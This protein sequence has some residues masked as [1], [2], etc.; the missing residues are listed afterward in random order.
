MLT[1]EQRHNYIEK[2]RNLPTEV[3]TLIKDLSEA[4]LT[5]HSLDNEWAV[6][7]IVHHLADSHMN[8]FIRLKMLLTEDHPT[9][10][11]YDQAA[12]AE[13]A[14]Q[15]GL[16]LEPSLAILSGLHQRWVTLFESLF[17]EDWQRT[18]YHPEIGEVSAEDILRSYAAHGEDHL[19]QMKRV[20]AAQNT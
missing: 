18:A 14:D 3:Q 1:P 6:A 17:G 10:K 19:A 16:P 20:L 15:S 2:I 13:M 11:P 4:Q 7:Q 8:S 12:W 9:L 5:A